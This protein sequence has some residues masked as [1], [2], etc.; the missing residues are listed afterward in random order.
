MLITLIPTSGLNVAHAISPTAAGSRYYLA[1]GDSLAAGYQN[2]STPTDRYC[3]DGN[4]DRAGGRGYVCVVWRNLRAA[5]Y[6][7]LKL[8]NLS[9]AAVP[10]EDTCSFQSVTTCSGQKQR[11]DAARNDVPPYNIHTD[12]QLAVALRFLKNHRGH[13]PVIS[14]DIGGD[15]FVPL[16]QAAGNGNIKKIEAQL[17]ATEARLKTNYRMIVT[18]LR[19]VAPASHLILI[20]QYNPASG[21]PASLFPAK[22]RKFLSDVTKAVQTIRA[23][24]QSAAKSNHAIFADVY[25]PFLGR[26]PYLTY[27]TYYN[28]HPNSAGYKVYAEAVYSSFKKAVKR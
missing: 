10:G 27:I 18:A 4:K 1:L 19:V 3:V 14:L 2:S 13:V 22:T 16:A 20:D 9:L 8:H 17:A 21:V 23:A 26:A 5:Y 28:V 6:H 7:D 12:S 24:V 25:T 15:D 11:H